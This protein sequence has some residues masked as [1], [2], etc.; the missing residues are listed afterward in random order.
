MKRI[1]LVLFGTA[2]VGACVGLP[3]GPGAA[4][5]AALSLPGL[6]FSL[7]A[8]M[9]LALYVVIALVAEAPPA[10][11]YRRLASE[12]VGDLGAFCVGLAP[13]LLF[14]TTTTS[15]PS[16]ALA[17]GALGLAAIIAIHRFITQLPGRGVLPLA[18]AGWSV[19]GLG[20]GLALVSRV[21]IP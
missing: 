21:V 17:L 15:Q 2:L 4:L 5:T 12:A 18:Y 10:A 20:L 16:A 1:L 9:A 3:S 7:A 14:L 13:A 8:L 6:V 19:V 11:E